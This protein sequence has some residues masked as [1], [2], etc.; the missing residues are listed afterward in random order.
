MALFSATERAPL[1]TVQRAAESVGDAAAIALI[2]RAVKSWDAVPARRAAWSNVAASL[3][4]G[5]TPR[6][7]MSEREAEDPMSKGSRLTMAAAAA[8][9]AAGKSPS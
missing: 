7:S 5:I 4:S 3:G 1:T 8:L 2:A 9:I 6:S